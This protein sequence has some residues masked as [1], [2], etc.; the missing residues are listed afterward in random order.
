MVKEYFIAIDRAHTIVCA[1]ENYE[2]Y[3]GDC[4]YRIIED[5]APDFTRPSLPAVDVLFL[6]FGPVEQYSCFLIKDGKLVELHQDHAPKT[7]LTCIE[8]PNDVSTAP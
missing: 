1:D 4:E 8:A 7:C 6:L 5:Y 2:A 3:F